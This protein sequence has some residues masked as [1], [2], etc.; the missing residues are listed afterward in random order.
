MRCGLSLYPAK[1]SLKLLQ[2]IAGTRQNRTL[3]IELFTAHQFHLLKGTLQIRTKV[4]FKVSLE[5]VKTLATETFK[6]TQVKR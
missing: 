5:R 3:N 6:L 1:L 4:S 2:F